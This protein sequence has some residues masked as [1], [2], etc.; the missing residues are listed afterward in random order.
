M[1]YANSLDSM[2]KNSDHFN[3]KCIFIY[4]LQKEWSHVAAFFQEGRG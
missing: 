4:F 3:F 2:D 1:L